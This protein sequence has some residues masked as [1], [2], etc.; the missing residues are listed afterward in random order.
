MRILVDADAC[1]RP[2]KDL[3]IRLAERREILVTFFANHWLTLPTSKFLSFEQVEKGFDVADQRIVTL[4]ESGDL[5]ITADI[6][7]AD[8]IIKKGAIGL[9]PRGELYTEENVRERLS[10]RDFMQDLRDSG[11]QTGGPPPFGV[12]D[13][14][15]FANSFN[16]ELTRLINKYRK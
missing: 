6:P 3:L 15:R 13:K 16:K 14:E 5:V 2:V 7:L 4:V 9:N 10:V 11:L 8:E 12:K 1:P